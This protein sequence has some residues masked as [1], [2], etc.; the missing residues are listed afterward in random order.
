MT[1]KAIYVGKTT[2]TQSTLKLR[3][4]KRFS[5][6]RQNRDTVLFLYLKL[7]IRQNAILNFSFRIKLSHFYRASKSFFSLFCLFC[8]PNIYQV[9]TFASQ[10]R[11]QFAAFSHFI[12]IFTFA[13]THR[14]ESYHKFEWGRS[15]G[16]SEM[17]I[18]WAI[19]VGIQIIGKCHRVRVKVYNYFVSLS[20]A[21][22][23]L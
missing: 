11:W 14:R 4:R 6:C 22:Q 13:H 1:S 7:F 2:K 5:T 8:V 12:V 9:F 17:E 16:E 23:W 21:K 15:F 18:S 20:F 10:M 3:W 19:N